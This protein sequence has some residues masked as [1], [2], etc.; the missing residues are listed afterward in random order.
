VLNPGKTQL[1]QSKMDLVVAGTEAAVLMVESE[2]QQLSEEVMLG[3]V[4]FGHQQGN[5]AINAIHDLVRDAGKPAWDWVA[6]PKDEAFIAKVTALAEGPLRAAYQ[7]R[8]KQART[9]ACREATA[10][11]MASL[12]AEGVEFDSVAVE[13]LLFEI[14]AHRARDPRRRA[15]H[16]SRDTE[17]CAIS[18]SATACCRALTA[19]RCSPV[20]RPR[21]WSLPR[22]APSATRR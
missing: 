7:I 19:R 1:L 21:R 5:I 16:G 2:A 13:G 4:V 8:S 12:K 22:W 15:A 10:N 14:E 6:A 20:A 11:V 17:P 3:G 18:R 9:Q